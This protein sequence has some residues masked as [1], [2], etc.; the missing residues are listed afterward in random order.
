MRAGW[1]WCAATGIGSQ[2][3][4]VGSS[5]DICSRQRET[6]TSLGQAA[7]Q[8]LRR[9]ILAHPTLSRLGETPQATSTPPGRPGQEPSLGSTAR[10]S[11]LINPISHVWFMK[12]EHCDPGNEGLA[13]LVDSSN[14]R[15]DGSS[16]LIVAGSELGRGT[17]AHLPLCTPSK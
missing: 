2:D 10:A 7:Q 8:Q 14:K 5:P 4:P 15:G 3:A 1:P 6:D 11:Q 17:Q 12:T 16:V 9:R 13:G